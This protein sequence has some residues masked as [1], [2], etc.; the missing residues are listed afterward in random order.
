MQKLNFCLKNL[1]TMLCSKARLQKFYVVKKL[2][3]HLQ[4]QKFWLVL[5]QTACLGQNEHRKR[6]NSLRGNSPAVGRGEC[7]CDKK[8]RKPEKNRFLDALRHLEGEEIP[9]LEAD[10]DIVLVNTILGK[11][12]P[13]LLQAYELPVSDYIELNLRMG[14]DMV[15]FADIWRL[16]RKEK[17]GDNGRI[18]YIDGTM[19]TPDSLN[20]IWYPDLNAAKR[21][22]E[23]TLD[24]IAGTG[25]GLVCSNK[26]APTV[27]STAVGMQ[28]YLINLIDAPGFI[29]EFQKIIHEYSLRELEMFASYK[30]DAIRIGLGLGMKSGPICSREM[31]EQFHYPMLREQVKIAKMNGVIVQLHVDG[32]VT[33]MIPDFIDMGVDL[34]H[35]LEP[36]D[37]AQDIYEIK[38]LYGDRIALH[39]NIDVGGVLARGKPEEVKEDTIEHMKKLAGGGGYVVGSSHDLAPTVPLENF[40]AMRDAV[41]A[42]GV[43]RG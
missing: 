19:K 40:Y 16:G 25:F 41:H 13:L 11:E 8:M 7:D 9:F 37:G 24:A 17:T 38:R 18:H 21:R 35:P 3:P 27:V 28:D 1:S 33:S 5:L 39:G 29:H 15:Y 23:E 42:H 30:V 26:Y 14:N 10:P 20:N 31:F 36:C 22:L 6:Y 2:L 12:F 34:L 43:R 4:K 32:N